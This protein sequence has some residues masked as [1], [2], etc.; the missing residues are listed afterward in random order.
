MRI[1][2]SG[3]NRFGEPTEAKRFDNGR[4]TGIFHRGSDGEW[5]IF[6]KF[7]K[8]ILRKRITNK[9]KN[10]NWPENPQAV[11]LKQKMNK[12]EGRLK[13]ASSNLTG[14]PYSKDTDEEIDNYLD[15]EE[16]EN[17]F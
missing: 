2:Y 16:N 8:P 12:L 7:N 1:E 17:N 14:K 11:K 10:L 4:L 9:V 6:K 15:E 3:R 13:T 5:V